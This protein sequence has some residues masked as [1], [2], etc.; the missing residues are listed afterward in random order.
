MPMEEKGP[1]KE[2]KEVPRKLKSPLELV[3]EAV[4][5][6]RT[7]PCLAQTLPST[8]AFRRRPE[9]G[10][11]SIPAVASLEASEGKF[12]IF[13]RASAVP[14]CFPGTCLILSEISTA[15]L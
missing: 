12:G 9:R 6:E 11:N 10:Q 13:V 2:T 7:R 14:F 8:D 15:V 4:G 5:N 1:V 3:N